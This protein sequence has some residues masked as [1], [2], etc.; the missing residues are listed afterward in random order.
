MKRKRWFDENL[1]KLEVLLEE[2]GIHNF[3]Y[4]TKQFPERS[5]QRVYEKAKKLKPEL[6]STSNLT[7]LGGNKQPS[8]KKSLERQRFVDD[9]KH[10]AK[11]QQKSKKSKEYLSEESENDEIEL[12]SSKKASG[13]EE[14]SKIIPPSIYEHQSLLQC[15]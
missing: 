12:L 15:F 10:I 3:T 4:I 7:L 11:A 1:D 14:S 13:L 6:F 5:Q 9:L 8:T 2:Y